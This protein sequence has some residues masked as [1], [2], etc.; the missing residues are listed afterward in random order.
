MQPVLMNVSARLENKE[1]TF[2]CRKHLSRV[3]E[4]KIKNQVII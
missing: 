2:D 1:S 3:E 4:K